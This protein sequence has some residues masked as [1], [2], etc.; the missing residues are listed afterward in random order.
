MKRKCI[1]AFSHSSG[2]NLKSIIP[3]RVSRI[4]EIIIDFEF[5]ENESELPW[6]N[7][8]GT[9]DQDIRDMNKL[10]GIVFHPWKR[11]RDS[12]LAGFN[13]NLDSRSWGVSPYSNNPNY[14]NGYKIGYT[15]KEI[16]SRHFNKEQGQVR[17]KP[18]SDGKSF[19]YNL[20]KKG[21]KINSV[22]IIH[23]MRKKFWFCWLSDLWFGGAN[24]S[25]GP[26]GGTPGKKFC[27][28]HSVKIVKK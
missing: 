13:F 7:E 14:P 2:I 1:S 11:S 3:M 25:P 23:V 12:I 4:K 27:M 5:I 21:K 8:D 15:G 17:M 22:E 9:T 20:Y 18:L 16:V 6:I 26:W 19:E 28:W 10:G 24:N